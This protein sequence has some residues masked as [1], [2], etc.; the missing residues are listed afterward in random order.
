MK[1]N[2]WGLFVERPNFST[3]EIRLSE[4]LAEKVYLYLEKLKEDDE[5][6]LSGDTKGK[7]LW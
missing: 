2:E 5:Y 1:I 3:Y 4:E 6:I 7:I